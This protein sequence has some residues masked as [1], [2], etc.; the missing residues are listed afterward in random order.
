MPEIM[1]VTYTR[2]PYGLLIGIVAIGIVIGSI[3]QAFSINPDV[4][5]SVLF[6]TFL[7]AL[8]VIEKVIDK[9]P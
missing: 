2:F 9:E 3:A 5:V 8:M 7:I 6:A 4:A 1:P